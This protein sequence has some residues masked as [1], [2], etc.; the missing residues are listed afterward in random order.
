[1]PPQ[2]TPQEPLHLR[3][4]LEHVLKV[5]YRYN[6]QAPFMELEWVWVRELFFDRFMAKKAEALRIKEESPLDYMPFIVGEFYGAT[7]IRLHELQDFTGWIKRGS[8]YQGLLV[9]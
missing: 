3:K 9:H 4:D 8:C 1:M 2:I 5:Y 7:R 6:L